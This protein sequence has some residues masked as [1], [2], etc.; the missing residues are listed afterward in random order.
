MKSLGF[1]IL[2]VILISLSFSECLESSLRN[3]MQQR[4]HYCSNP[5][6]RNCNNNNIPVCGWFNPSIVRCAGRYPCA[7]NSLNPCHACRNREV[8]YYTSGYCPSR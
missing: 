7:T 1:G 6:P 8:W 5:R 4:R 2:L 3:Q